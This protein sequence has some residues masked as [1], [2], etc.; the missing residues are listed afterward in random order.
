MLVSP[1]EKFDKQLKVWIAENPNVLQQSVDAVL[2]KAKVLRAFKFR[3]LAVPYH[4]A[5]FGLAASGP[6][7]AFQTVNAIT[8]RQAMVYAI[9]I[10]LV[11]IATYLL[12]AW[13]DENERR[14]SGP[15][16]IIWVRIGDLLNTVKS[17]ATA[18][19]EKDRSIEATLAIA[20]SVA[21]EIA[22]VRP[23]QVSASLV[24]Y[25]GTGRAKMRVSHRNSGSQRPV[26]RPVKSI[27]TL[28]GHH[29]CL[30][31]AEA[32]RVVADLRRF[33]PL[34][35][36]S[37]TQAAPNYRSIFIQP[38]KSS[39]KGELQG[40]ISVDCSVAHGFHGRRSDDL[41]AL[42]EPLKAHIEDM[43]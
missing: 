41:A 15:L 8:A 9:A 36:K 33:G 23:D 24:Q 13:S 12:K 3:W 20:A 42:L 40:F 21:A 1:Q 18:S 2:H 14:I 31:D 7:I 16:Q 26:G 39:K 10:W 19:S 17:S 5:A 22:Q 27:Q 4:L 11:L 32:P 35:L 43:I 25:M 6:T 29:A 38:V 30:N 34:G 37:P 28:L